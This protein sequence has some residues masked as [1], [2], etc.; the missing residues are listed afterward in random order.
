MWKIVE[1]VEMSQTKIFWARAYFLLY[2][3]LTLIQYAHKQRKQPADWGLRQISSKLF[4]TTGPLLATL[5]KRGGCLTLTYESFWYYPLWRILTYCIGMLSPLILICFV[6]EAV[7]SFARQP[8]FWQSVLAMLSETVLSLFL[9]DFGRVKV[10]WY[11]WK[12]R[13][14]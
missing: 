12:E 9:T 11:L 2:F 6:Y 3:L 10:W 8:H 4:P 14:M 1:L 13:K 5:L 7:E